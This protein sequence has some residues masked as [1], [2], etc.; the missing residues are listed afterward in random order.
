MIEEKPLWLRIAE[1]EIGVREI[2]GPGSE[3]RIVKYHASTTLKATDDSV[4]W[5]SSFVN[6]V[7]QKA[8]YK[9]TGLANARS[10]L[11]W[12]NAI[13]EPKL[14]CIVVFRRTGSPTAGHVAFYE[15]ES[16]GLLLVLGGNQSDQVRLSRYPKGSVLGYRW[17][18]EV[19]VS[20]P[21]QNASTGV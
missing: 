5:C 17:P 6:W 7:M 19:T 20:I 10:W 2:A 12:G 4:P 18:S 16:N 8:G 1:D 11:K 9:G 21:K 13:K 15:G 3:A 14:G